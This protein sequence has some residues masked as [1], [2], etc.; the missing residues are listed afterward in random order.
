MLDDLTTKFDRFIDLAQANVQSRPWLVV[1]LMHEYFRSLYPT[2]PYLPFAPETSPFARVASV[3]DECTRLFETAAPLGSYFAA[4][5]DCMGG[6]VAALTSAGRKRADEAATQQVYGKLWD[7]FDVDVYTKEALQ[8][9]HER[10]ELGGFSL[11]NLAGKIVLDMGCGSGRYT[12]ALAMSGAARVYGVDMG[13]ASIE[14]GAAIARRAGVRNI[15]F[16]VGNVLHLPYPDGYFDFV[17]SNGVLHHTTDME[18]GI[19]EFHRVLKAGGRGFLYLYADGGL[20]WYSRKKMPVVMKQIPQEYTMAVLQLLGMPSN[21]FLFVDNWY[22]PIERHSAR[23]FLEQYLREVGFSG[24]EKLS[25]GR[26]TDLDNALLRRE[27]DAEVLW[28]DGEHRYV[29]TKA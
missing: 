28:G 22:V 3:L 18:Q 15:E 16:Q 25:S 14:S 1:V 29:L 19:R 20:F 13:A 6:V 24:I 26:S 8:I 2:D 12:I 7:A 11:A 21:R 27:P 5:P 17:F 4:R 9:L 23:A 10:L